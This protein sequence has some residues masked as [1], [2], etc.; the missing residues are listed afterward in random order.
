[1]ELHF[2]KCMKLRGIATAIQRVKTTA[3]TVMLAGVFLCSQIAFGKSVTL[4]DLEA[5]VTKAESL[6]EF[7][8]SEE[9]LA[10]YYEAIKSFYRLDDER[11]P[12]E[13]YDI[14]ISQLEGLSEKSPEFAAAIWSPRVQGVKHSLKAVK[15]PDTWRLNR[16]KLKGFWKDYEENALQLAKEHFP[17]HDPEK[18]PAEVYE[19]LLGLDREINEFLE[20]S[21]TM[22]KKKRRAAE[23]DFY[24][25][26]RTRPDVKA[27]MYAYSHYLLKMKGLHTDLKD[28]EPQD[29]IQRLDSVMETAEVEIPKAFRQLGAWYL[30]MKPQLVDRG[31]LTSRTLNWF[32]GSLSP[33]TYSFV[34]SPR[35]IHTI[36]KGVCFRECVGGSAEYIDNLTPER[37][38]TAVL[39]G[40]QFY[41]VQHEGENR[42]WVQLVPFHRPKEDQT[43][44]N[45]E[46]GT[47]VFNSDISLEDS[48]ERS[49][50]AFHAWLTEFEKLGIHDDGVVIGEN[51]AINNSGSLVHIR[52]SLPHRLSG[53]NGNHVELEH[54]DKDMVK[55]IHETSPQ[56]GP[57][58]NDLITRYKPSQMI[59]DSTTPAARG[60]RMLTARDKDLFTDREKLKQLYEDQE[61]RGWQ[62]RYIS[63]FLQFDYEDPKMTEMISEWWA[64]TSEE[65]KQY[66]YGTLQID[67]Q[68]GILRNSQMMRE[69]IL[70]SEEVIS[71][72]FSFDP[73]RKVFYNHSSMTR[74]NGFLGSRI[75]SEDFLHELTKAVPSIDG[76]IGIRRLFL[77]HADTPEKF[78]K[79]VVPTVSNPNDAYKLALDSL[80]KEHLVQ[81]FSM[82]PNM[83]QLR[84]LGGTSR[85]VTLNISLHR[86]CFNR[87]ENAGEFIEC[88]QFHFEVPNDHYKKAM[89]ELI[90]GYIHGFIRL[91]PTAKEVV[92]LLHFTKYTETSLP[93]MEAFVPLMKTKRDWNTVMKSHL[94]VPSESF[95]EGIKKLRAKYAHVE[96]G[97]PGGF[98]LFK[99]AL[100][101]SPEAK[102]NPLS[103]PQ[104][105]SAQEN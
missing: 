64:G 34:P 75:Y 3:I 105:M 97:L 82:G 26:L 81:F 35:P 17:V 8:A 16:E 36:F 43:F 69:L 14:F 56:N 21:R 79:F 93:L 80:V 27:A 10:E 84:L 9:L 101:I 20:T 90:K 28:I 29:F 70:T 92:R 99:Q 37:W 11:F 25:S 19:F 38:A 51:N 65:D 32:R 18:S 33:G 61:T 42:G 63:Q 50:N 95:A 83:E 6:K 57:E 47:Q 98:Q 55:L 94:K 5:V 15:G 46:S 88:A 60:V 53:F 49:I 59:L 12:R 68:N 103:C 44:F 39:S 89:D 23:S 76:S 96:R 22:G 74:F 24:T 85:T 71:Q 66:I 30:P 2:H 67:A 41:F 13:N 1:M 54:L 73:D 78:V 100:G 102:G 104:M 77:P 40:V 52:D 7:L 48:P 72:I 91:N 86:N 4:N 58:G 45:V 62:L 31:V 87:A